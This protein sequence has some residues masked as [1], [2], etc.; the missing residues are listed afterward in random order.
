MLNPA[1]SNHS[2]LRVL[3]RQTL[4]RFWFWNCLNKLELHIFRINND[5]S[6]DAIALKVWWCLKLALQYHISTSLQPLH[7]SSRWQKH[8]IGCCEQQ[9]VCELSL[10]RPCRYIIKVRSNISQRAASSRVSLETLCSAVMAIKLICGILLAAALLGCLADA[11]SIANKQNYQTQSQISNSPYQSQ[12]SHNQQ[13]SG[14]SQTHTTGHNEEY[15]SC[16]V[17][18]S[19]RVT[20]G[21]ENINQQACENINC[22]YQGGRCYFA[23]MGEYNNTASYLHNYLC[24]MISNWLLLCDLSSSVTLHCTA[25]AEIILVVA[26]DATVPSINLETTSL[27]GSGTTCNPFK[28][29][30]FVVYYFPVNQ[31]GTVMTV[32]IAAYFWLW[33]IEF[34]QVMWEFDVLLSCFRKNLGV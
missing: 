23:K 17:S 25:A 5:Q 33:F 26:R 7:W 28:A 8:L 11:K 30:T 2:D 20:C 10:S 24:L 9:T 32:R 12:N 27:L 3:V 29:A 18:D 6:P 14:Q 4:S 21:P 16:E 19:D 22:C 1:P 15:H 13:V 34:W 31:C